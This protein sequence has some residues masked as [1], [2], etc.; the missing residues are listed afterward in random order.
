MTRIRTLKPEFW[1]DEKLSPLQAITRLVFLGLISM[2]DDAG[3]LVDNLKTIDGFVFP[4]TEESSRE[5]LD[6]LARLSRIIRY[7]SDSGQ[8]L[9]EIANWKRHQKVDKPSRYV[10]PP[11]QESRESLANVSRSDLVPRTLDQGPRTETAAQ[12]LARIKTLAEEKPVPGQETRRFIRRAAVEELGPW[13]AAAYDAIGGADA[14]LKTPGE[15]WSFLV[16]DF[17]RELKALQ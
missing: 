9:I 10:L 8:K 13:I 14:V 6:T 7:T 17:E 16:R 12:I 5:S 4:S 1:G 11:S 3:R 15:R 2:A